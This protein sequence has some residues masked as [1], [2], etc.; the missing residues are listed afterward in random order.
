VI[1]AIAFVFIVN[2][3][4][5][6]LAEATCPQNYDEKRPLS[7]YRSTEYLTTVKFNSERY[8]C[9]FERSHAG[10]NLA[11]GPVLNINANSSFNKWIAIDSSGQRV[12]FDNIIKTNKLIKRKTACSPL[13]ANS[14]NADIKCSQETLYDVTLGNSSN[15][16][17]LLLNV[18]KTT[19]STAICTKRQPVTF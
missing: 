17:P 14:D 16:T 7:E 13:N 3:P 18:I 15:Q 5:S 4:L 1:R 10:G 11:C 19:L 8:K 2:F 9:N 6:A 12:K